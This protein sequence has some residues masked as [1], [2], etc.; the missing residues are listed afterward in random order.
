M[1]FKRGVPNGGRVKGR[2]HGG[3]HEK[4]GKKTETVSRSGTGRERK[5]SM[6]V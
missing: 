5:G 2:I 1:I 3:D 6:S 4:Q